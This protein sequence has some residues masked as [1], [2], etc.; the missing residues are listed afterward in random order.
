MVLRHVRDGAAIL[1]RQ[2]ALID[3]LTILGLPTEKAE[4]LLLLFQ[5]VQS[6]HMSHLQ[7]LGCEWVCSRLQDKSD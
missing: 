1:A 3:R 5:S 7:R 2:K 6:E 4:E